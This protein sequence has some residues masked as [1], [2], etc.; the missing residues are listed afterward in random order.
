MKIT[1]RFT[2]RFLLTAAFGFAA[3][4]VSACDTDEN[5]GDFRVDECANQ[6]FEACVDKD[7][8]EELC[9]RVCDK[10][11]DY[12]KDGKG[13][14]ED[15]DE[16][17]DGDEERDEDDWYHDYDRDELGEL[18]GGLEAACDAGEDEACE[19]LASMREWLGNLE[20][21]LEYVEGL[22]IACE[23]ERDEEACIEL[24]GVFDRISSN[25]KDG[26]DRACAALKY[27]LWDTGV[28]DDC[29]DGKRDGDDYDAKR[30]R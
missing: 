28:E 10:W 29:D 11:D 21:I 22:M 16:D 8:D 2:T 6:C 9:E 19:E 20:G 26:D 4:A 12:T 27:V 24:R 23:R 3:I 15:R 25:C 17:K 18:L 7:A 5:G 1:F 14:Y 30:G 13:D